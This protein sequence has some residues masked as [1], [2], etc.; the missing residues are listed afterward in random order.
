M[1]IIWWQTLFHSS[2]ITM[3]SEKGFRFWPQKSFRALVG[4][5]GLHSNSGTSF[6][7]MVIK[8]MIR[9]TN[10]DR[11]LLSSIL[12]IN[13]NHSFDCQAHKRNPRVGMQAYI[14]FL[15]ILSQLLHGRIFLGQNLTLFF[16]KEIV[17]TE[18]WKRVM[19]PNYVH[20]IVHIS[21]LFNQSLSIIS[22]SGRKLLKMKNSTHKI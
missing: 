11:H 21:A 20:Q 16:W 2:V 22:A 5:I 1:D 14:F 17:I 3:L 10:E 4:T 13:S 8:G 15:Y 19:P 9:I 6:M 12:I 7:S 18:E